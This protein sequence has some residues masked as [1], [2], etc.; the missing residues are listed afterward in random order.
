MLVTN[1]PLL[2]KREAV[3]WCEARL[4]DL[5][6]LSQRQFGVEEGELLLQTAHPEGQ[7]ARRQDEENN[8]ETERGREDH[9]L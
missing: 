7:V 6:P 2:L 3:F 4:A 5:S 8:S 9:W 1:I